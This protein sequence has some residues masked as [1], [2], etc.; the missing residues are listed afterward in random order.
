MGNMGR[1]PRNDVA[2]LAENKFKWQPGPRKTM[3]NTGRFPTNDV[4][5]LAEEG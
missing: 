5:T 4:A 1:L 2:A 3:G